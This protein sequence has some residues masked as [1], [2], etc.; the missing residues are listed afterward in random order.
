[1]TQAFPL[2][3]PAG[4]PRTDPRRRANGAF[5]TTLGKAI[6]FVRDEVRRMGGT[7][8]VI[9]ADLQFRNDGLPY[10]GWRQ[11]EDSGVAVYFMRRGKQ[12][13]FAC[14]RWAK[15]E[16]NI[17]AIAKT[18][19][20]MRGIERWGSAEMMDRA[21][22]GFAALPP[23]DQWWQVLGVDPG[24]SAAEI[25]AAYRRLAADAHPDRPGGSDAAMARLN[26]ARDAA[27]R[28]IV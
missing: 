6:T 12:L 15:V 16:H 23:P 11:P 5:V 19:E 9:S 7:L 28:G 1:M 2:Q 27:K 21:F 18:I 26:A 4:V 25:S 3:W 14:D 22:T 8:P 20:A 13:V 24:A 10:A 17:Q